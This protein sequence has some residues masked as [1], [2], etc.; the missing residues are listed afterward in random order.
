V[1]R[2][3]RLRLAD[4]LVMAYEY[5]VLPDSIVTFP[6]AVSDSLYV[7]LKNS[8]HEPVRAI[9]HIRAT[10]AGEQLGELMGISPHQALIFASRVSFC[11]AGHPIELTHSYCHSDYYDFVAELR[12]TP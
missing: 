11:S 12:L 5:S 6:A 9:Q 3:E 1:A 7:F 8:G 4:D 2:L 10:N